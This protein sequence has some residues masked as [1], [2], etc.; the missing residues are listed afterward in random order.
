MSWVKLLLQIDKVLACCNRLGFRVS[1]HDAYNLI[2]CKSYMLQIAAQMTF[3]V[4]LKLGSFRIYMLPSSDPS[5]FK[6]A[7]S[8][9]SNTRAQSHCLVSRQ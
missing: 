4:L 3:S 6:L 9:A 7:V 5:V 8:T 1:E 2:T